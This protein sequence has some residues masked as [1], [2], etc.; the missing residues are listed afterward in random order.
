VGEEAWCTGACERKTGETRDD[1]GQRVFMAA[2]RCGGEEKGRGSGLVP[3]VCRRRSGEG[4]AEMWCRMSRHGMGEAAPGRS[5][6]GG[7]AVNRGGG[8]VSDAGAAADRWGAS[9]RGL[10]G[11]GWVRE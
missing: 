11:S 10:G 2:R 8:G 3:R 1:V 4:G 5:D 9:T 7:R 6:S